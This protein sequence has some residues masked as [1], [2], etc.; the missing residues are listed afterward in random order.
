M[1]TGL[2]MVTSASFPISSRLTDQP[3]HFMFRHAIFL[4]LALCV[5]TVVIQV[6]LERWLRFSMALLLISVGLLFIVLIAGKSVNGASRWIPLGLFNLQ[7]AEVAKL[8]L[9]IF[10][11]G[12]LVRKNEEVRSSFFG[13]FIKPIIVFATLAVLLLL[14]PDLG[15]VVV[16]LVTLFGMLFIAGAK[17][18]QF[19]ALMVVGLASVAALIYFEPYRWRRVTSFADPWED[20]FGSGYQLTQSLMAFGRGEWFG[21]GLGNSIQKLEYLPEAHT[22]FVFAVLAEEL[23]FVGVVLA[24]V[25]IFSLVTKAI[26]IGRKAFEHQQLFGGYLAFG[27][28]IWFAFQTLVNVGAAA[29]MVP[30]KGLTLPLISYGGSSLIVMS[31][32]V[33]ILLRIDHECRMVSQGNEEQKLDNHEKE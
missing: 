24:L 22:D 27:I 15:T 30:T 5:A 33:S 10:M 6:P 26:L 21:Q 20:P 31:V 18:T 8:S 2:V 3:F 29:G 4:S 17:M 7:P 25:L 12:Y 13:G 28:G 23:G 16:M 14:Q 1:L 11:S 19:L 9:F 32:A